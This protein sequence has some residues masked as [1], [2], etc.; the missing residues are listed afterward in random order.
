MPHQSYTSTVW[1]GTEE[2]NLHIPLLEVG[3]IEVA[4]LPRFRRNSLFPIIEIC[5]AHVEVGINLHEAHK[6]HLQQRRV[7]W[8]K[9]SAVKI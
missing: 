8:A 4:N 9:Q 2:S 1:R 6:A 5:Q 7:F 3:G